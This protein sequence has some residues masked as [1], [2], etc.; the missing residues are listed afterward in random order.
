[1]TTHIEARQIRKRV[2]LVF[3]RIAI[4]ILLAVI[5]FRIV[6]PYLFNLHTDLGL[7]CAVG[8]ALVGLAALIW[9]AFDTTTSFR[10]SRRS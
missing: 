9:F 2:L 10:Q 3:A 7:I 1:V 5:L 4:L 6:V 8:G